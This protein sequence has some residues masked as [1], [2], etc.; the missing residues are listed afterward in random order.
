MVKEMVE[1]TDV[2]IKNVRKR[3]GRE[4]VD[5]WAEV[6]VCSAG[7]R[8]YS[9]HLKGKSLLN[10]VVTPHYPGV[11]GV[12]VTKYMVDQGYPDNYA[13]VWVWTDTT[14]FE[15]LLDSVWLNV[16]ALLV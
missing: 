13:S 11:A 3:P 12:F 8:I 9:Y 10:L 5:V 2:V 6:Q 1:I 4:G 7:D 14:T 15:A 16:H